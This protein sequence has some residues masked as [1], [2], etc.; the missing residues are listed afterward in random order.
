MNLNTSVGTLS[1]PQLG[2]RLTLSGRD[3]KWHVTDYDLGG[4][5]LLYSTAEIFT[6]KKFDKNTVLVT[7]GGPGELHELSVLGSSAATVVEGVGITTHRNGK[8]TTISWKTQS[9]RRVV[10]IGDLLIYILD[11]NSAYNYWVPDFVRTDHWGAFT[12]SI[13]QTASVI[14]EA[15]YLIRSV[16]VKGSQLHISGDLNA[17]VPL[18]ILGAPSNTNK[19]YFNGE[20]LAFSTNPI[21]GEWSSTLRYNTPKI[22]VPDLSSLSWK[23]LDDLPEIQSSYDDSAWTQADY[24]TS[25][26]TAYSLLT[27]TSLFASDYGYNS[28]ILIYRGWFIADGSESTFFVHTQGGS[29]F[30]SSVF[31]NST[32]LGSWAGASWAADYNSTYTLPNLVAGKTY[33]LTIL[34]DNN[35][36]D[37]NWTVGTAT[38][39]NPRGILNYSL[40]GR[41][42]SAITWK[43]TGNLHGESYVDKTRGPLNEGGLYAERQGFTQPNPPSHNWASGDPETG[44]TKAGVAF[45]S[46]NF[47]LD[48]P[49]GYDIPM[50]FNF[51]TTIVDGAVAGYRAQLWVNG[52]QFGKY[53]NNIGPQLSF[54]VPQGI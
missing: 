21:T 43:L 53:I 46:T 10:K 52:Y 28:G 32:Y 3:S 31:L 18:N 30:G 5:T 20:E 48:F 17:T 4:T 6:W 7:Y 39:K 47:D 33:V 12:T 49:K 40:S 27:P 34:V 16:S 11:R 38:M 50:T 45:Y 8:A 15:G 1:V 36:L 23:Y 51:A 37:E 2:G 14:I 29:A 54:P 24:T 13:D 9:S 42:Q 44:I 19:L 41:N 26:N 22:S 35:G 25:N